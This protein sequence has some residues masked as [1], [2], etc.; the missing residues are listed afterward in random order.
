MAAVSTLAPSPPNSFGIVSVRNPR[1]EPSR[2]TFQSK[3]LAG[4]GSRSAFSAEGIITSIANFLAIE[5]SS[6]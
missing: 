4:S 5:R 6:S 1:R 2:T 3:A